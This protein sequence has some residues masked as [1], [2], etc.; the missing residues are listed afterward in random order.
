MKKILLTSS[1]YKPNI[2]G[3]E[4]SLYYMANAY[5]DL[6]Y[7]VHIVAS[8]INNLNTDKL[9]RYEDLGKIKV[10][11]YEG[12]GFIRRKIYGVKL[13][14]KLLNTNHY[15]VVIARTHDPLLM[16]KIAGA[17]KTS[18]IPPGV[19]YAQDSLNNLPYSR[20]LKRVIPFYMHHW[21]QYIAIRLASNSYVF[22]KTMVHQLK[23][24]L[25]YRGDITIIKPGIDHNIFGLPSIASYNTLRESLEYNEGDI[26]LLSVGRFTSVKGYEYLIRSLKHLPFKYKLLLVGDGPD[27]KKYLDIVEEENLGTRVQIIGPVN[28]TSFFY[29]AADIYI[30]SSLHES[31]GQ[32]ILEALVSGLPIVA[33]DN[34]IKG[35]LT[36]ID[37]ITDSTNSVYAQDISALSLSEAIKT[38]TKLLEDKVFHKSEISK[39]A[40]TKYSWENTINRVK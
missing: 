8:N 11:R 9:P 28:N 19:Y 25:N 10:F 36:A 23:N 1:L 5:A 4:N 24:Y 32:T 13:F 29:K 18:Y 15:E 40:S 2:G 20:Y 38:A 26:V 22:S 12:K 33:F 37:E 39:A 16:L 3:I 30:S 31:L 34:K 35:V 17:R 27:R 7:E 6:G 14:K 21:S